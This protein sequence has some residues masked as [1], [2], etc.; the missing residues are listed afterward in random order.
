MAS[1]AAD[2]FRP[3]VESPHVEARD[4]GCA[5]PSHLVE[6]EQRKTRTSIK[7]ATKLPF[8]TNTAFLERST[9]T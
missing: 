6:V 4:T 7:N 9:V 2:A 5:E 8:F 3:D 1:A